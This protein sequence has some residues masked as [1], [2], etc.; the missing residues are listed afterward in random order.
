MEM[1]LPKPTLLLYRQSR[2][3]QS[4]QVARGQKL[5]FPNKKKIIKFY[6]ENAIKPSKMQIYLVLRICLII[7]M[8]LIVRINCACSATIA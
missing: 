6:M 4:Y 3:P 5:K 2:N 8:P 1:S 7:S